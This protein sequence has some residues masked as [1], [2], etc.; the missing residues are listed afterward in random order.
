MLRDDEHPLMGTVLFN[1]QVGAEGKGLGGSFFWGVAG[2]ALRDDA[3]PP[4]FASPS[5]FL[6]FPFSPPSPPLDARVQ[7]QAAALFRLR[8]AG[9]HRVRDVNAA[10]GHPVQ[11]RAAP[12]AGA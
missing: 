4:A 12:A 8:D 10:R 9:R 1:G 2:R 7:P 11:R 6:P 5:P 3:R